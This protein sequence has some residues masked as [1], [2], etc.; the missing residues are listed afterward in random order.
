MNFPR[1]FATRIHL[2]KRIR[3][4]RNET[5]PDHRDCLKQNK[6]NVFSYRTSGHIDDLYY[7]SYVPVLLKN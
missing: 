3:I 5:D 6:N 7:F 1:F 4:R 2:V